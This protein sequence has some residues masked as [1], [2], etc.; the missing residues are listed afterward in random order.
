M[1]PP[2]I[3]V[4]GARAADA[5]LVRAVYAR[6]RPG[7][8]RLFSQVPLRDPNLDKEWKGRRKEENKKTSLARDQA[9]E[10]LLPP[11]EDRH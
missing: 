6:P 3:A 2:L 11:G 4:C 1:P 8:P 5:P 10:V 7:I 9:K